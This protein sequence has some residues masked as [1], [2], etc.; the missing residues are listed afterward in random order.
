MTVWRSAPVRGPV[1]PRTAPISRTTRAGIEQHRG[2]LL[3]HTASGEWWLLSMHRLQEGI[4]N[5]YC[6]SLGLSGWAGG[7][8]WADVDSSE[9]VMSCTS[10]RRFFARPAALLLSAT[11]LAS[12]KP[13]I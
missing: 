13:R 2:R 6:R 11:G 9:L 4:C 5:A 7:L 12:P 8:L 3:T 1:V 10:T